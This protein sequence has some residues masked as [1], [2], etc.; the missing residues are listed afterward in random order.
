MGELMSSSKASGVRWTVEAVIRG[1]DAL[2]G[3]RIIQ[4]TSAPIISNNIY[5]EQP[6]CTGDGK[7]FAF[8]RTS[9]LT[10]KP[11][12]SLW[13]YDLEKMRIAMIE[14]EIEGGIGCCKYTGII[15]YVVSNG[16]E[17]ELIKLSLHTLERE[18]VFDLSG[19]PSFWTMGSVTPDQRYYVYLNIPKPGL[20]QI[21]RLDLKKGSWKSIHKKSDIINPHLQFEPS[22]GRDLLIQHNRGGL[23][24]ENG[25][26]V[27]LVGEEGGTLYVIDYEG[28][29][30]RPLPVGKPYTS[31]ITGHECWIGD[32][33]EIL[34]TVASS[35]EDA[36]RRGNLLAVKPG[37]EAAR[38][39]AKGFT[40]NHIS[41]SKDGSFFIGDAWDVPGKPL[42]LGSIDTGRCMVLCISGSSGGRP[43]YTHPHPYFTGDTGWVIFNSD[44][45]GVPQ[46]YAASVPSELLDALRD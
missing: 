46:I 25:N 20:C 9:Y 7:R 38:R 41:V 22:H 35:R 27:R 34:L 30:Y 45:T 43:Q 2:S 40:L 17:R 26:I 5:C 12:T 37:A 32:T 23:I 14:P 19:V 31:P 18:P 42:V 10:P 3:S 6:Y 29:N 4:L 11:S 8:V 1:R 39:I 33:G 28:G 24:D 21:I 36:F 44:R 15:Y 13:V 16:E